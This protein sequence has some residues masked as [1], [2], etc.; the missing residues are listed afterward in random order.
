MFWENLRKEK[1]GTVGQRYLERKEQR[2]G[3]ILKY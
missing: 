3:N 1:I 2:V